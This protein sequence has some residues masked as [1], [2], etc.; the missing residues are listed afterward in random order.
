MG[1]GIW[2]DAGVELIRELRA[3][4]GRLCLLERAADS[5]SVMAAF[6]SLLDC[7][8]CGV[9]LMLTEDSPPQSPGAVR[10]QL[11]GHRLLVDLDV[12]FWHS[13]L[14]LDPLALIRD[15]S[16]RNPPVIVEWPGRLSDGR[17]TY[18]Q[19]SRPDHFEGVLED[20]LVLRPCVVVF[21]DEI[22]YK[23]E[24]WQR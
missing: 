4:R 18:S 16:R 22:P 10:D 11:I 5:C 1:G 14:E 15:L 12:L 23:L 6:A 21:P 13:R 3:H 8:P 24:R 17:A 20:A 19:V 9:G 2:P 7:E